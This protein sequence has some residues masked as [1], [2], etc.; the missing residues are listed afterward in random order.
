MST[1]RF[2]LFEV[3]PNKYYNKILIIYKYLHLIF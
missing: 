2:V 3:Y 1:L